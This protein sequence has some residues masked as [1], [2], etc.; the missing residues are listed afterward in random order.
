MASM[1]PGAG[2]QK[3][4]WVFGYGSLIWHPGFAFMRSELALLNGA[5]RS[6]CIYSHRHRGTVEVPGLVFGLMRGGSC[7]G[8]AFEV[9]EQAWPEVY[10]YL[11]AREQDAGVYREAMRPL[12]LSS[13]EMVR[14]LVFLANEDHPQFAGRLSV[15]EQLRMVREG[16][17]QSGAN[18][19]YVL[20]T[21]TH[22]EQMGIPDSQLRE[23]VG[24][25][26][27]G[28]GVAESA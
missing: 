26:R 15:E 11:L 8:M 23:L 25:L 17:G 13:G 19:D 6:L 18:T 28:A 5:H 24:L 27:A 3:S 20:N 10:E 16:F 9:A 22:L 2:G 7:R 12:R 1:S 21:A 4:H 14:A